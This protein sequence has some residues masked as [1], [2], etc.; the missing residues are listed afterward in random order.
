MK[1]MNKSILNILYLVV[2]FTTIGLSCKQVSEENSIP[3][4]SV[5]E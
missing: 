2:A 1:K 3:P 4:L 5:R